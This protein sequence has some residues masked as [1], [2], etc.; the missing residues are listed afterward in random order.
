MQIIFNEA[1]LLLK[2]YSK[3]GSKSHARQIRRLV[4]ASRISTGDHRT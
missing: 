4:S 2:L 3:S 1:L